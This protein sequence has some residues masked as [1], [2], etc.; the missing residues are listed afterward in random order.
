MGA[1]N[2]QM[3][4]RSQEMSSFGGRRGRLRSVALDPGTG[5]SFKGKGLLMIRR[6]WRQGKSDL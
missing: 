4:S 6:E 2:T 3:G 1:R 5:G